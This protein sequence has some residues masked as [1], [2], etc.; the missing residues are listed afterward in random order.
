MLLSICCVDPRK[1]QAL[2]YLA[3]GTGDGLSLDL[4]RTFP[5]P[6]RRGVRRPGDGRP[7]ARVGA[8]MRRQVLRFGRNAVA[9]WTQK[10]TSR[11]IAYSTIG[12]RAALAGVRFYLWNGSGFP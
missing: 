1:P 5:P 2:T 6:G 7:A 12:P 9:E 3:R 8:D 11:G 4:E 10:L